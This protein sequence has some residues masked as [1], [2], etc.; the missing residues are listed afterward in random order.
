MAHLIS[1]YV[2][3]ASLCRQG[4]PCNLVVVHAGETRQELVWAGRS[5][6][7]AR[8]VFRSS[9]L[10]EHMS[11]GLLCLPATLEEALLEAEGVLP[12][13]LCVQNLLVPPV[14]APEGAVGAAGALLSP[15]AG[16]SSTVT[17][18]QGW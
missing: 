14:A 12:W 3:A 10:A 2:G 9:H 18:E 15:T 13:Q 1:P 8:D 17:A 6:S 5:I 11:P 16:C 7:R 4:A